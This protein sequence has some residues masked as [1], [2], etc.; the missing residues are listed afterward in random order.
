MSDQTPV[1]Y[2]KNPIL[3]DA[4]SREVTGIFTLA[5]PVGQ[6]SPGQILLGRSFWR[7]KLETETA[8]GELKVC[9]LLFCI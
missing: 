4:E 1:A 8:K 6:H 9:S 2:Q 5:T 3:M 7:S